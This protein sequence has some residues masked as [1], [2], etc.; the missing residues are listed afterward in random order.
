MVE[1]SLG[2]AEDSIVKSIKT[3]WYGDEIDEAARRYQQKK[4]TENPE[5]A[6]I[7][8]RLDIEQMAELARWV[9]GGTTTIPASTSNTTA[10]KGKKK[11]RDV[12]SKKKSEAETSTTQQTDGLKAAAEPQP[13]L[14]KEKRNS[15]TREGGGS[16]GRTSSRDTEVQEQAVEWKDPSVA[17]NKIQCRSQQMGSIWPYSFL[18]RTV[19]TNPHAITTVDG[20][21]IRDASID[22][23][24]S[25]QENMLEE[26]GNEDIDV[27]DEILRVNLAWVVPPDSDIL[28]KLNIPNWKPKNRIIQSARALTTDAG[29]VKFVRYPKVF[30]GVP[31]LVLLCF[32]KDMSGN[33]TE[34]DKDWERATVAEKME[35]MKPADD[36]AYIKMFSGK[37]FHCYQNGLEEMFGLSE[38]EL[39]DEERKK[40]GSRD[41]ALRVC[42]INKALRKAFERMARR[43][44]EVAGL[45]SAAAK[46]GTP[47]EK[48]NV[49]FIVVSPSYRGIFQSDRINTTNQHNC[50]THHSL[51]N[52]RAL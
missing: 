46:S 13:A 38:A 17:S 42:Q 44:A 19:D 20:V 40:A 52:R 16:K 12:P 29:E 28:K 27:T 34:A 32:G 33:F 18:R 8:K 24:A 31:R 43:L 5:E 45:G 14:P 6:E 21:N 39:S 35:Q 4:I 3:V 22:T 2:D 23:V 41:E 7:Y 47:L 30:L 50:P 37:N 10:R 1:V 51:D 15:E 26:R 25:I 9:T 11:R 48:K 36:N 49:S